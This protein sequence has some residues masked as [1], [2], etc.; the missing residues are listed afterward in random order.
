[1][2]RALPHSLR[3]LLLNNSHFSPKASDN[4][5]P[6]LRVRH[7]SR[8]CRGST[9]RKLVIAGIVSGPDA[10][11]DTVRVKINEPVLR[12]FA[13]RREWKLTGTDISGSRT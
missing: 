11:A 10:P 2:E 7:L 8:R 1:M 12:C 3:V 4:H 6:P 13:E 5:R 9:S